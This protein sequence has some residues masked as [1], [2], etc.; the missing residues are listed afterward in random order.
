[1]ATALLSV[2]GLLGTTFASPALAQPGGA[3]VTNIGSGL[4]L[5]VSRALIESLSGGAA[6]RLH[7]PVPQGI[8]LVADAPWEGNGCGYVTV[9]RDA[10]RYRM[11]YRGG[12]YRITL[13]EYT[14]AHPP[15]YCYAESTDG[16]HWTKPDL[17]LCE[18]EGSRHNNT[19]LTGLG[20]H[21]FAP[22]IDANPVCPPEARYKAIANGGG[23]HGVY[24][25][26]SP[27]GVHWSLMADK[28]V[29]TKGAFDS[30][31][32]AFWDAPR[33][34]YR[35]YFRDFRDGRDIRTCTSADFLTWGEPVW[36]DYDPGRTSE[37]YT[38]QV[39]PYYR[40]PHLFLG[41]PTRYVDRGWTPSHDYL[42]QPEHRKVRAAPSPREG[43]AVTDGMF[44]SS[45]DGQHFS[46]W[47][48]SFLRP[49]LRTRDS[50]FYG[51]NYQAWGFVET[52]P[53]IADAPPE[54]SLY[55]TERYHQEEGGT[56][57][58]RYTLRIDG[59]V[60]VE[61]PL[62]GG[63]LVT[64]PLVFAGRELVLNVSTSAAGSVR[65]ELQDAG[66]AALPGFSLADCPEV[67]GDSLERP[68][69]WKSGTDVSALAGRPIRL[70][71]ELRDA[72]LYSIRFR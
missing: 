62:S 3:E 43:S 36:L 38:N 49:G 47:P 19:I 63:E 28:P 26:R 48:E 68:V 59:F 45:R 12:N 32:L 53:A 66:G 5:F 50:W 64:R 21:S 15:V 52:R 40:A 2:A 51:D 24:A 71:L 20:T 72:D 4:E 35:A 39:L 16:I 6:L 23:E 11:Y 57:F 14:E 27:D 61:A 69:L 33:G 58:R 46:I 70:R 18:F 25:F 55:A 41:F 42:P 65:V 17:G 44:M 29:I 22:F 9:F 7:H 37:L 60:S 56:A 30:Q 31:N 34:E 13:Q 8:A 67:F 10:D 1:V 54:L